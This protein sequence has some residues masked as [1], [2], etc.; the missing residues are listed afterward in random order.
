[1]KKIALL[2]FIALYGCL[3]VAMAKDERIG[4]VGAG[5]SGLIAAWELSKKGYQNVKVLEKSSQI[6]GKVLTYMYEGLPYE[7]G[8]VITAPDYEIV[9]SLADELGVSLT[10]TPRSVAMDTTGHQLSMLA[11]SKELGFL[12]YPKLIRDFSTF[13]WWVT[14]HRDFFEPGFSN[15]PAALNSTFDYFADTH[16]MHGVLEQYRPVMVGCGYGYAE[17]MPA[18]YWMKLMKTFGHEYSKNILKGRPFYQGFTDG[19]QNLWVQ[20][21]DKKRI[22]VR[23]N[24]NVVRIER[25]HDGESIKVITEDNEFDFDRVIVTVPQLAPNFLTLTPEETLALQMIRTLP[26]KTTLAKIEGLPHRAHMWLRENS[27]LKDADGEDND[28]KPVL[29]SSNQDTDVY[30]IYQ[31]TETAKT[32]NALREIMIRTVK[33][34][35][36]NVVEIIHEET[37]SYFPHFTV[38]AFERGIPQNIE[39]LQGVGGIYYTGALFNFETVELASQHARWMV[40]NYF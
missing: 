32:S 13:S 33:N 31:F 21:V 24:S 22:D 37:F 18:A 23:L 40:G 10:E 1:M 38:A 5:P 28:G 20:L 3:C 36:A 16:G 7:M 17:T 27:Y 19:W 14:H 15:T 11:W 2:I 39:S 34:L 30:Q 8:A 35:G 6:G 26:Y 4:I 25:S 29:I 9:L 12:R